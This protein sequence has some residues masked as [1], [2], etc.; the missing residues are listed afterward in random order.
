MAEGLAQLDR[1]ELAAARAAFETAIGLS[2]GS[3]EA[4]EGLARVEAAEQLEAI[5]SHRERA[6]AFEAGEQW[7]EAASVYMAVLTLDPAIRFAKAGLA[8]ASARSELGRQLE[9]QIERPDR[10]SDDSVLEQARLL[11][12]SAEQI[13]SPGP[14][15]SRQTERLRQQI[16]IASTPV[17]VVLLSD[18][19][20]DVLVYK[21]GRL[22]T[23]ERKELELR[24]GTYT[25]V[26]S[27]AGFQ[28]VRQRLEVRP[29]S[30]PSLDVRCEKKI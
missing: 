27:R 1:G 5:A 30:T 10:L 20:T 9:A 29:D 13:V 15:L 7:A 3:P 11:L 26:G 4:P 12:A 25:V 6:T 14:V 21:V 17:N 19:F 2:P 8:R 18:G 22:G 24:P 23:F 16:D 28:D